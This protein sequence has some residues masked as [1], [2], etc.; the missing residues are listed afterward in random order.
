MKYCR[1]AGVVLVRRI[2][3]ALAAAKEGGWEESMGGMFQTEK[4]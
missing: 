3:A 1:G 4:S 2:K